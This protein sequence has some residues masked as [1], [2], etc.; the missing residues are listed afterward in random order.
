MRRRLEN[1]WTD[2][3]LDE[4]A[5]LESEEERE[6]LKKASNRRENANKLLSKEQIEAV[7][8]YVEALCII[9]ACFAKKAFLKGCEF[10]ASF[11][12]EALYS[13]K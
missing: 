9:N 2:Y 6:L 12:I 8:E 3:L 5:A 11:L 1:L 13:G 10:S 7:D 4:C